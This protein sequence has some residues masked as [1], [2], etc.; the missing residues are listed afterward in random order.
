MKKYSCPNCKYQSDLWSVKRHILRVHNG[1]NSGN[2]NEVSARN[3][4]IAPT[5]MSIGD[6]V[7]RASTTMYV[8][9]THILTHTI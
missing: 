8:G 4:I 9:H 7:G 6:N 3:N 1:D 5:T 2:I